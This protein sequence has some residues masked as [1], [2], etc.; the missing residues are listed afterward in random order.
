MVWAEG[1][2]SV[3]ASLEM[4][5]GRK[6]KDFMKSAKNFFWIMA[7]I[8][9]LLTLWA[10]SSTLNRS[11]D[12]AGF[13]A[14]GWPQ[15]M[16]QVIVK[17]KIVALWHASFMAV[18]ITLLFS[19]FSFPTLGKLLKFKNWI[20]AGL[21]L[22]V[23]ADVLILSKHYVQ[24]MPRS[25]IEA[26]ALTDFL[27]EN[28][29]TERVALLTQQNIYNVWLTYLLPY[30]QIAAFNFSQM[31]RMPE[32][33]Q[34]FLMAGSKDPLRMWRFSSVKYLLGPVGFEKQ[35][36]GQ[37]KKV[38][39]YN[40]TATP[41]GEIQLY[42]DPKGDH[43][44][45]ELLNTVPRYALLAGF[46]P[47]ADERALARLAGNGEMLNGTLT[48]SV[49]VVN[50][51][52]GRVEL[53]TQAD[54]PALLRIAERWDPDWKAEV[55]GKPTGLQRMDYLC[56][57]I[58]LTSGVHHVTLTYSPSRV[59]FYMQCAG[60]LVFLSALVLKKKTSDKAG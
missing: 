37:A 6:G 16:A 7:G 32:D 23:S 49:E 40:L 56:Q 44:V 18:I 33:Y 30:N 34:N 24:K 26:N 57:G 50:Y 58:T 22:L 17:N 55:D 43:A 42:P 19:I 3:S 1:R 39:A 36:V 21:V 20:A 60:Y 48:G 12:V 52:P 14:Q 28:L 9:V 25:Y 46:D 59:F 11:G 47:A 15:Q 53:K 8:L 35:L 38:F 54:V 41:E 29:G 51:R 5:A 2:G 31:P 27:K 13:M 4:A 10:L 45:F